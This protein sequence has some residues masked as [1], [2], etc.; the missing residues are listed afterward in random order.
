MVQYQT[1]RE[2]KKLYETLRNYNAVEK[3]LFKWEGC[4]CYAPLLYTWNPC[5]VLSHFHHTWCDC[6]IDDKL[7]SASFYNIC[8]FFF[9]KKNNPH[10]AQKWF[11]SWCQNVN[12]GRIRGLSLLGMST[13]HAN[14]VVKNWPQ[15]LI[16][17][18][19]G[20]LKTL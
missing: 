14:L 18:G 11:P 15:K 8:T 12:W 4:C 16:W 7:N 3:M 20:R 13:C 19:S 10:Q 6:K 17:Y 1:Y 2:H 5:D 9:K